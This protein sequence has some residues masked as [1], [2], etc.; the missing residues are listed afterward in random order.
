MAQT[1]KFL[2]LTNMNF[3]NPYEKQLKITENSIS[4]HDPEVSDDPPGYMLIQSDLN[5]VLD[6]IRSMQYLGLFWP[7]YYYY[8]L[9]KKILKIVEKMKKKYI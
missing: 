1:L 3:L 7:S 2:Q 4:K 5:M 8:F 9:N 6:T